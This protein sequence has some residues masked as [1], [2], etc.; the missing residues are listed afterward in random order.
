MT[1]TKLA[2]WKRKLADAIRRRDYADYVV[3]RIKRE[4]AELEKDDGLSVTEPRG[5]AAMVFPVIDFLDEELM[6][7]KWTVDDLLAR[8]PGDC[9]TNR[10]AIDL[11]RLRDKRI[12]LGLETAE[13]I[14]AAL[15]TSAALWMNLDA[16]YRMKGGDAEA[17]LQNPG[18]LRIPG[19]QNHADMPTTDEQQGDGKE[20]GDAQ[21]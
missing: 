18:G 16:T 5:W 9:A 17:T 19:C 8:M 4:I 2:T 7:R 13:A 11:L 20:G 12:E 3:R 6:A 1:H 15:G 10:L 14:A 21:D